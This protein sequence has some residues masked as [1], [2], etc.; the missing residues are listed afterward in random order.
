M[1]RARVKTLRFFKC[2]TLLLTSMML[3]PVEAEITAVANLHT[4]ITVYTQ[5]GWHDDLA[6]QGHAIALT[7]QRSM[8]LT[9]FRSHRSI[10]PVLNVQG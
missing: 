9:V 2:E 4:L 6:G 1:R 3:L 7:C 10:I 5:D 8:K